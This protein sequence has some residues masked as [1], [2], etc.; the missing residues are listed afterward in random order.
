MKRIIFIITVIS[1]ISTGAYAQGLFS[2]S[3]DIGLPL[4]EQPNT[5]V[6][7]AL[8]VWS[9]SQRFYHGQSKLWWIFQLGGIL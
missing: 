6:L 1:T 9:R 4:G 8:E 3:Y 5:L 7:Q 2:V